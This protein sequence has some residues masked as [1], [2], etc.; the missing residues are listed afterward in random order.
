M[1]AFFA[2]VKIRITHS[3]T[4]NDMKKKTIIRK[5]Y[6]T[7]CKILI[8]LFSNVKIACGKKAGE[9]LYGNSKY[10]IINNGIDLKKYINVSKEQIEKLKEELKINEKELII[11][12]VGRFEKVKNHEYFIELA[13]KIKMRDIPFKIVLVGNGSQYEIIKDKILKEKLEKYF[14]LTGT[15]SDIN[16]FMKMFDVFIMPSLYEGFPLVVVEAL[17]GDNI[18]YLSDN[19]SN[20]TNIIDNR[21]HFFNIKDDINKLID[22]ILIDLSKKE[23]IEIYKI[24]KKKGYSISDTTKRIEKIYLN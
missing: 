24:I 10:I 17:A 20:E 4:T 18:C 13:K 14:I 19:I 21:V 23:N 9:Y 1:L 6:N 7:F 22:N 5:C 16:I 2:G 3:H 15:R 12:H 11:G 8:K